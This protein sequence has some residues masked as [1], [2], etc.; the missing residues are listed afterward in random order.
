MADGTMSSEEF[1]SLTGLTDRRHRQLAKDGW[2]PDP[3]GGRWRT[4]QCIRGMFKYY[5][6]LADRNEKKTNV[7]LKNELLSIAVQAKRR[8]LIPALEVRRFMAKM[9]TGAKTRALSIPPSIA[10]KAAL[11]TDPVAI[12]EML[13]GAVRDLLTEMEKG[14]WSKPAPEEVKPAKK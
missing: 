3:D 2:F 12:E 11:M 1:C 4:A 8:E 6:S 5:R 10:P 14:E 13:F 9:I 7:E